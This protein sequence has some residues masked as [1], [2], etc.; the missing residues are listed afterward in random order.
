MGR[1]FFR[2]WLVLSAI[3]IGLFIYFYEPVTYSWL[4]RAPKYDFEF[5][6][7]HKITFDGS[8]SDEELNAEVTRELRR[9]ADRETRDG[10][11]GQP[12]KTPESFSQTRDEF[13]NIIKSGLDQT[14]HAWLITIIP[15]FVLLGLGLSLAWISR[16][17]RART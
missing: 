13:L 12:L 14:K 17:F 5:T 9:E 2:A 11:L 7:G 3:W 15:P 4:W 6:G 16:G 10:V 8:K 1:G